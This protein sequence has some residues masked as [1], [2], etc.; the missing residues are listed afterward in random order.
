ML[1]KSLTILRTASMTLVDCKF[2]N[3][4]LSDPLMLGLVKTNNSL[5]KWMKKTNQPYTYMNFK[6]DLYVRDNHGWMHLTR[7]GENLHLNYLVM[8][9][10]GEGHGTR[11]MKVLIDFSDYSGIN[12][13]LVCYPL[14]GAD[15]IRLKSFY[16]RLGFVPKY[17]YHVY[18]AKKQKR[19][20]I[21]AC[22][23]VG[24][25]QQATL[26]AKASKS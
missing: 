13:S 21:K 16:E 18:M 1:L 11:F 6:G 22:F 19:N 8:F 25:N 5:L 14:Q 23:R 20:R 12:I 4:S 9:K 7:G 3:L 26:I 15:P 24:A 17:D 10:R 2:A